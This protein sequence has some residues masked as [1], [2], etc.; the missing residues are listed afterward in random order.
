MHAGFNVHIMRVMRGPIENNAGQRSLMSWSWSSTDMP[1]N[2]IHKL[3]GLRQR[4]WPVAYVIQ[5][6]VPEEL[7][8][9]CPM[10]ALVG[11]RS[12]SSWVYTP[13]CDRAPCVECS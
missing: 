7:I 12:T 2:A 5:S 3:L 8:S 13:L 10:D 4:V 9:I 6:A 11:A 1:R